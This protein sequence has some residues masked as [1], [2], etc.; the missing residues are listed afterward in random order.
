ML[1]RLPEAAAL[2]QVGTITFKRW[3]AKGVVPKEAIFKPTKR[4]LQFRKEVLDA[5]FAG[6]L[7]AP[8]AGKRPVGRPHKE[9]DS[10]QVHLGAIKR[11]KRMFLGYIKIPSKNLAT[12]QSLMSGGLCQL[13]KAIKPRPG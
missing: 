3:L 1:L 4:C 12:T 10:P 7:S 8:D 6:E 2:W 11:S 9:K 5:W 13:K